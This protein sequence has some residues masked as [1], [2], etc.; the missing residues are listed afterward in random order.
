MTE[1][2]EA[3]YDAMISSAIHNIANARASVTL[4]ATAARK[5]RLEAEVLDTSPARVTLIVLGGL[6]SKLESMN[7]E[8]RTISDRLATEQRQRAWEVIA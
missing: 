5:A 7:H 4:A 8:L 1:E 3:D 2:A 6:A